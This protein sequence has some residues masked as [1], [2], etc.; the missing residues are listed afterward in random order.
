M[1]Q[2]ERRIPYDREQAVLGVGTI[3]VGLLVITTSFLPEKSPIK[4]GVRK[5]IQPFKSKE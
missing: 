1:A 3:L 5:F 2:S 4:Q